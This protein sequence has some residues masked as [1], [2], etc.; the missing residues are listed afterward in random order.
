MT[1][2]ESAVFPLKKEGCLLTFWQ[3][4]VWKTQGGSV[5]PSKI[6]VLK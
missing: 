4:L 6:F 1:K 2:I 3:G 5:L